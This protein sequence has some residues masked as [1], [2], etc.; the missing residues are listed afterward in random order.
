MLI[1]DLLGTAVMDEKQKHKS[2]RNA[3]VKLK[4]DVQTA[5]QGLDARRRRDSKRLWI[6]TPKWV[7]RSTCFVKFI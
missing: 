2:V 4:G 6:D 7:G 3:V 1:K 5:A